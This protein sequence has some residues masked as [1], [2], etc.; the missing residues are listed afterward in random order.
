M[1]LRPQRHARDGQRLQ[2]S[3]RLKL[4]VG[5]ATA[6]RRE[7][8]RL[9]LEQLA[10]QTRS[11]DLVIVCPASPGD[12]ES[13]LNP[14]LPFRVAVVEGPRGLA[15]QRN[16][17]LAAC[18]DSDAVVFFDDDFYAVSDYL[19]QAE[20][21]LTS[22]DN[23]VIARGEVMADGATGPGLT[24]AE[25]LRALSLAPAAASSPPHR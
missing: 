20:A 25:A 6:G 22:D 10:H 15:A 19:H 11:P 23:I 2:G 16:R 3:S 7:Q 24:P 21:L 18:P 8:V 13:G 4:V 1:G 14:A 5:I 9:T 12:Y 17:I